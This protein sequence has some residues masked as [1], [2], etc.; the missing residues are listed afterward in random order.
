MIRRGFTLIE[1]M[2]SI[3]IF[4]VV[5]LAMMTIMLMASNIYRSGEA[6]RSANDEAVAVMAALDE[7]I[8]RM[9]PSAGGGWF[10]ARLD[11][12]SGDTTIAFRITRRDRSQIDRLG[13]G[14]RAIVAWWLKP[15]VVAGVTQ[16]IL[17]RGEQPAQ[18]LDDDPNTNQDLVTLQQIL[19]G[20]HAEVT[21]G[22]LHFGAYLASAAGARNLAQE[23]MTE[24]TGG[25]T[26]PNDASALDTTGQPF[27]AAIRIT[28]VL[29]GGGRFAAR[30]RLV[31]DIS[32][33]DT[34]IRIVGI[35]TLSTAPGSMVKISPPSDPSKGEWIGYRAYTNGQLDCSGGSSPDPLVGRGLRRS[36][37]A[38]FLPQSLVEIGQS[39][40]LVRT[41]PH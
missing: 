25:D 12:D 2:V 33:S 27:P 7:D 20:P 19:A 3:L 16:N 6:G 9:I 14:D 10:Y 31:R 29:T 39:Y 17:C 32:P 1:I 15:Q 38:K 8:S 4:T 24:S 21:S 22:C 36:V 18:L 34:T 11:S 13:D 40:S 23:W 41:L 26:L 30:G 37:K 5:A 35:P 28:T